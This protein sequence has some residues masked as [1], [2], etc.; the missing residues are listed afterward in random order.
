MWG[1]GFQAE[2]TASAKTLRRVMGG[3]VLEIMGR[4]AF[5]KKLFTAEVT[6]PLTGQK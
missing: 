4:G 2:G 6:G 3:E 5:V 1:E